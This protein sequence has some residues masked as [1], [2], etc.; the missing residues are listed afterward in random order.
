M[1]RAGAFE[2]VT[3]RVSRSSSGVRGSVAP[4]WVIGTISRG[5]FSCS[6]S[7]AAL[8]TGSA[9]NRSRWIPS[10]TTLATATITMPW[11]WA[12]TLRTTTWS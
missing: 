6:R 10:I 1:S 4:A 7:S 12:I 2:V 9:W 5:A 11:W 3:E 8:I